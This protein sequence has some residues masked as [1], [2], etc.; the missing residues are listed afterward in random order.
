LV[1]DALPVTSGTE[2]IQRFK[3]RQRAI[4]LPANIKTE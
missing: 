1:V 4:E 2:K 3:P